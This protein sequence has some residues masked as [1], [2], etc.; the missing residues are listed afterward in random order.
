MPTRDML[1]DFANGAATLRLEA[2]GRINAA[3]KAEGGDQLLE[4]YEKV[5]PVCWGLA[6]DAETS[7]EGSGFDTLRN[8]VQS[9]LAA[10]RDL[11]R[12]EPE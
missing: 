11:T 5:P 7:C 1:A 10:Q 4:S 12:P 9:A 2:I 8:A 3:I 6:I